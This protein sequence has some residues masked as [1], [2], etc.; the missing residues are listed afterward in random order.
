MTVATSRGVGS[1][2]DL[3]SSPRRLRQDTMT[4]SEACSLRE[5]SSL[6][7]SPVR[8][9]T[10]LNRHLVA[11]QGPNVD[12]HYDPALDAPILGSAAASTRVDLT[13]GFRKF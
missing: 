11:H 4:F 9:S 5:R 12:S 2:I 10:R 8:V 6:S 3:A 13:C 1:W 7:R